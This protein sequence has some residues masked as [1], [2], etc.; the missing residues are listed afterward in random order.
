MADVV[1]PY[2]IQS[3]KIQNAKWQV[4]TYSKDAETGLCNR[5]QQVEVII[6]VHLA[7]SSTIV[8]LFIRVR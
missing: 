1:V 3:T 4:Y 7:S 5:H 8:V 6:T 2:R